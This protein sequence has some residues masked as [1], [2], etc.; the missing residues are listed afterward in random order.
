M[1]L[2]ALHLSAKTYLVSVGIAD[3]SKFPSSV[4][5]LELTVKDAQAMVDLLSANRSM[6][7]SILKDTLATKRNILR[8][9]RGVFKKAAEDDII[10]FFFSG[11]GYDG[12]ICA[13]DGRMTYAEV[14][15][16]MSRSR[17]KN[18]IMFIDACHAGG[19]RGNANH[20]S[21]SEVTSAKK[22]NVMLFLS[23]RTNENS[24][25]SRNMDH[26]YFTT[27][28]KAGLSGEA[29][30]NKDNVITAKEIFTYVSDGVRTLSLEKQ[31]P[32]MWG[33]F[34]D[35]MPVMKW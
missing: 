20:A 16:A 2:F 8:Y 30:A 27:Y 22:A 31:H 5:N 26:G 12:G 15:E 9:I 25:E 19:L 29:D 33:N 6:D 7:Y 14:R 11:H 35:D 28:L 34:S 13:C 3:Y 23:S 32:V 4:N 17:C 21:S 24:L 1:C 18:K 10:I